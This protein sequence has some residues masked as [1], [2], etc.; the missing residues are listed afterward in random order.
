MQEKSNIF[1]VEILFIYLCGFLPMCCAGLYIVLGVVVQLYS[2]EYQLI[3]WEW[4]EEENFSDLKLASCIWNFNTGAN[5]VNSVILKD[6]RPK[7]HL[8]WIVPSTDLCMLLDLL[9]KIWKAMLTQG[10]ISTFFVCSRG[11]L[12]WQDSRLREKCRDL[13]SVYNFVILQGIWSWFSESI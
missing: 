11:L 3:A 1:E 10:T 12:F 5:R 7:L 13:H 9:I 4:S 2:S 6:W 8:R